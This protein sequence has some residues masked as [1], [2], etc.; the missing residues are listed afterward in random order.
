MPKKI[1]IPMMIERVS[2]DQ[3]AL[4]QCRAYQDIVLLVLKV[5][6]GAEVISD[7]SED[8]ECSSLVTV[9]K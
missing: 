8:P 6:D 1:W 7:K 4:L 3:V 5:S 2:S 9:V